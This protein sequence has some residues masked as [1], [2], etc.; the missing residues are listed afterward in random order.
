MRISA[1]AVFQVY[2]RRTC[3]WASLCAQCVGECSVVVFFVFFLM[4]WLTAAINRIKS[5]WARA[6]SRRLQSIIIAGERRK[7][8]DSL[9]RLHLHGACMWSVDESVNVHVK[10]KTKHKTSMRQR[11]F[12]DWAWVKC[13]FGSAAAAFLS[14]C[15]RRRSQSCTFVQFVR[16]ENV[17]RKTSKGKKKLK[18]ERWHACKSVQLSFKDQDKETTLMKCNFYFFYQTSWLLWKYKSVQKH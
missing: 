11:I 12:D 16:R 6:P 9:L 13:L 5:K 2:H 15:G 17:Q 7:H 8:T 4:L 14:L 3:V 10:K 1:R 18:S